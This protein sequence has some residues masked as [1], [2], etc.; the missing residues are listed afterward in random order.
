MPLVKSDLLN[1]A[2]IKL[3]HR[4][5]LLARVLDDRVALALAILS[6]MLFSSQEVGLLPSYLL[7]SFLLL[8]KHVAPNPN[9]LSLLR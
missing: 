2:G 4:Q 8:L 5:G 7:G 3:D 1:L 6:K 9:H